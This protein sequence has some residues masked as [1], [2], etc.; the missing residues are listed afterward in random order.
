MS[1]R[2]RKKTSRRKLSRKKAARR[3][4]KRTRRQYRG[5]DITSGRFLFGPNKVRWKKYQTT[6]DQLKRKYS[7]KNENPCQIEEVTNGGGAPPV[8]EFYVLETGPVTDKTT[9]TVTTD[10]FKEIFDYAQKNQVSFDLE[11]F[12][13]TGEMTNLD[14]TPY[15]E[16]KHTLALEDH[17][18]V[19]FCGDLHGDLHVLLEV[20]RHT[21]LATVTKK[22]L[23]DAKECPRSQREEER[24][25]NP[26]RDDLKK[27]EW[28]G[29][30]SAIVFLGD[31]VDNRREHKHDPY[32]VCAYGDAEENIL[33][34]LTALQ[35]GARRVGGRVAVVLGNHDVAN[36]VQG[37]DCTRYSPMHHC[38]KDTINFTDDWRLFVQE[39]INELQAPASLLI[40][41][42][43]KPYGIA[44][45]G[46]VC[47]DFW[48]KHSSLKD[49]AETLSLTKDALAGEIN[50]DEDHD[51][52][53]DFAAQVRLMNYLYDGLVNFRGKHLD[54]YNQLGRKQNMSPTWCRGFQ[55]DDEDEA[56]YKARLAQ[57]REY[58]GRFDI[59]H[60]FKAHDAHKEDRP[61][62]TE[63]EKVSICFTDMAMSRCFSKG[64]N[65]HFGYVKVHPD[66]SKEE[67]FFKVTRDK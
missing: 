49:V 24:L 17:T 9:C 43:G 33:H 7:R 42:E 6:A 23:D 66:G 60:I 47:E 28:S 13:K 65:T 53:N 52:K 40:Y 64:K 26:K 10:Q 20:L 27:L 12:V 3:S 35:E 59:S 18:A 22:M 58:V 25:T 54:W 67:V 50:V 39:K 63:E 16:D 48:V 19:Y 36:V 5:S 14:Q 31:V 45:H 55:R 44:V 57:A 34:I 32:G 21:G 30:M 51:V 46:L 15:Q 4:P 61:F 38:I 41:K 29:G 2:S 56:A 8:K 1:K 37:I 11:A 62:C